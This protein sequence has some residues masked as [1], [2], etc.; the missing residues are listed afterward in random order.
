M[1][2][3][4]LKKTQL[5]KMAWLNSGDNPA[6][7][8]ARPSSSELAQVGY[9]WANGTVPISLDLHKPLYVTSFSHDYSYSE[10]I[11]SQHLH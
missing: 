3:S 4:V 8:V 1:T 5:A 9:K 11:T 10:Q 6:E 2:S 7:L